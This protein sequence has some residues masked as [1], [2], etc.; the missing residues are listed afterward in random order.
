L[1]LHNHANIVYSTAS[2][3]VGVKYTSER[4]MGRPKSLSSMTIF[5]NHMVKLYKDFDIGHGG[6]NFLLSIYLKNLLNIGYFK[7]YISILIYTL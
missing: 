6:F 7:A 3:A 1:G 4:V 2:F 5:A